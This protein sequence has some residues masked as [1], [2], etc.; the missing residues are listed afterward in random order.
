[1]RSKNPKQVSHLEAGQSALE[2]GRH[3]SPHRIERDAINEALRSAA[4]GEA[5]R[6]VVRG[7]TLTEQVYG[8]LRRGLL[9][10]VWKP[11]ERIT[12]RDF[13][14]RLGVSLTPARE[15][16]IRLSNEGAIHVTEARTFFVP[17]MGRERYQSITD[18]RLALEPMAAGI[19]AEKHPAELPKQL[20]TLNEEMRGKIVAGA[21]DE[22]LWLDSEFHLS[23]YGAARSPD[24]Q[25]I[26]DSLWLQVGPVRNRL[27]IEYRRRLLGYGNHGQIVDALKARDRTALSAAVRKDLLEGA[28]VILQAL[29]D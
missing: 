12:A 15:A 8:Q 1:M 13:S 28:T 16:I 6:L 22:A 11:G 9:L 26:I 24:L 20:E 10:G 7:S 3:F 17:E 14:R 29:S 23:L 18:I 21:F 19:A 4:G 5:E 25:R 2:N 27:S